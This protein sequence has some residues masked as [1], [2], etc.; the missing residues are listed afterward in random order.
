MNEKD[1]S[2]WM[3]DPDQAQRE[4]EDVE[5]LE[6]M[7]MAWATSFSNKHGHE[8]LTESRNWENK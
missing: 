3:Q 4:L 6:R 8:S 7:A 1:H 5:R 2:A